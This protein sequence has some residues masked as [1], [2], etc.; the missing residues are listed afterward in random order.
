MFFNLSQLF[1]GLR[2]VVV[3]KIQELFVYRCEICLK[4]LNLFRKFQPERCKLH[5]QLFVALV[6][7]FNHFFVKLRNL[8][9]EIQNLQ[10]HLLLD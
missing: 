9:A 6:V 3:E 8:Q 4:I 5:T 7:S 2:A 10:I 1:L